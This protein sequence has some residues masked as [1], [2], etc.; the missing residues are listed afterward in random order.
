M[1]LSK[2]LPQQSFFVLLAQLAHR[3]FELLIMQLPSKQKSKE[4]DNPQH[5]LLQFRHL[6]YLLGF[7]PLW[8]PDH[9]PPTPAKTILRHTIPHT[10]SEGAFLE[11][12]GTHGSQVRSPGCKDTRVLLYVKTPSE[13]S[14]DPPYRFASFSLLPPSSPAWMPLKPPSWEAVGNHKSKSTLHL[15]S[16]IKV[17]WRLAYPPSGK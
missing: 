16:L 14:A 17:V 2:G 15:P 6:S 1:C 13:N 12:P 11:F 9:G 3:Y 5:A 8:E 10:F 4:H 7:L